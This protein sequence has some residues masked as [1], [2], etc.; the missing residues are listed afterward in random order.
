MRAPHTVQVPGGK[1]GQGGE[2]S[3]GT[4]AKPTQHTQGIA[5]QTLP[6]SSVSLVGSG[7]VEPGTHLVSV[8]LGAATSHVAPIQWGCRHRRQAMLVSARASCRRGHARS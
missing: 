7:R 3:S 8:A 2:G 1:R 5:P 4:A 6:G